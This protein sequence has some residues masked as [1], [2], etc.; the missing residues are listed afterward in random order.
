MI[1]YR[2]TIDKFIIYRPNA[3]IHSLSSLVNTFAV[4]S[5]HCTFCICCWHMHTHRT[6]QINAKMF[7]VVAKRC[8]ATSQRTTVNHMATT[9]HC[10][11]ER[12]SERMSEQPPNERRDA[13][14]TAKLSVNLSR[15]LNAFASLPVPLF[16]SVSLSFSL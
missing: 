4:E 7:P 16:L 5:A 12:G 13:Q 1:Y 14:L 8:R 2:Y 6:R 9:S 10:E 3:E 11:R 15:C